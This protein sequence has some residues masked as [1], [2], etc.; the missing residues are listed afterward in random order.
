MSQS[1]ECPTLDLGSGHDLTVRGLSPVS[2]SML[3]AQSLLG[4]LSLPLFLS[5]SLPPSIPPSLP[6]SAPPPLKINKLLKKAAMATT[7]KNQKVNPKFQ[8]EIKGTPN[9]QTNLEKGGQIWDILTSQFQNLLQ[10]SSN[11]NRWY[12]HKDRHIDQWNRTESPE[13]IHTSTVN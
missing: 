6:L 3:T 5:S 13:I 1:V 10:S 9:S 8:M 2:G 11:Q 12:W 7:C 4:I